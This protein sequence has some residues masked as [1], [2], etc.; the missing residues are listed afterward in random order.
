MNIPGIARTTQSD[1]PIGIAM[2][3][4]VDST[5]CALLLQQQAEVRGFFMHLAQ[6]DYQRQLDRVCRI[7]ERLGMKLTVVDLRE[8]FAK[9]VLDYFSRTYF[10]GATPN[11]CMVCN[12]EIKFGLLQQTILGHNLNR[13]ATGHYARVSKDNH[14]YHLLDG[15]DPL[16]NQSYFLSRLNQEQLAKVIFPLG[17]MRKSETYELVKRY[18][19]NDFAGVESQDVCF[20]A[21]Q[22][23]GSYLEQRFPET[24]HPGPVV[25]TAG[26]LVGQHKGLFRYTIGQRRGLG[27]PDATPWYVTGIEAATNTLIVGKDHELLRYTIEL[28]DIHW[29]GGTAPNPDHSFTVRIRYSHR[30]AMARIELTEKDHG[31]L[32]FSE[33]QRAIT[34]GQFAVISSGEEVLGSGVIMA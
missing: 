13:M 3:G 31:R 19:F 33:P 15:L 12:R 24:I 21:D 2:S 11:P 23:V 6:P 8:G 28:T 4:G 17:E 10:N 1:G 25:S 18:G 14:G 22:S 27:I 32:I 26:K 29:I 5:A 16:K 7:T 30:G 34:P 9:Q 20:L